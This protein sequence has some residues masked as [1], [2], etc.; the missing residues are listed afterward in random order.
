MVEGAPA[1]TAM[2]SKRMGV[3]VFPAYTARCSVF[4]EHDLGVQLKADGSGHE[5]GAA[6]VAIV[7]VGREATVV[8]REACRGGNDVARVALATIVSFGGDGYFP[9]AVGFELQRGPG[10]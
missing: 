1:W 7:D 3:S 6:I 4:A 5:T 10:K 8:H 9:D 2:V